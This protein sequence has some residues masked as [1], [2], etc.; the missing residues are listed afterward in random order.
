[1]VKK[2]LQDIDDGDILFYCDSGAYFT[3]RIK[4]VL[5]KAGDFNL[6]VF[7]LP[8]IEEQFTKQYVLK[9]MGC[10]TDKFKRSNQ[11]MAT[12]FVIKKNAFTG[13]FVDEWLELCSDIELL[14]PSNGE[15]ENSAFISHREDQ[16]IFS[17]LC[18]KYGVEPKADISQRRWFPKTY[19]YDGCEYVPVKHSGSNIPVILYLHK[20]KAVNKKAICRQKLRAVKTLVMRS[21]KNV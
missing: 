13:K 10:D 18:K 5:K 16:S 19:N 17:L 6:L 4:D 14:A 3:R 12:Y 8:L 9:K 15:G 1:M 7:D 11:I 2:T 20:M 21:K